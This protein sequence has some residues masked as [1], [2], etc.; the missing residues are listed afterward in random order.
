MSVLSSRTRNTIK[1]SYGKSADHSKPVSYHGVVAS[2]ESGRWVRHTH[3]VL[4]NLQ[5]LFSE[6]Q[7]MESSYREF[8]I[9]G[10]QRSLGPYSESMLR[11]R[12]DQAIIG[13]LT[14]D[15]PNQQTVLPA[16]KRIINQKIEFAELIIAVRRT[17]GFTAAADFMRQGQNQRIMDEF[18]TVLRGLRSE[19]LRLLVVRDAEA[20]R[21]WAQSKGVVMFGTLLGVFLAA[22]TVWGVQ[23]DRSQRMIT[24]DALFSEKE[25]APKSPSTVSVTPSSA[26]TSW[27]ISLSLIASRKA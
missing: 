21:R 16:L 4:Q 8:V 7:K 23:R 6:V 17:R 2:Q 10:D 13:N 11:A 9:T 15:N 18:Q 22:A 27:G 26:R 20:Q 14:V 1:Q 25:R 24:E 3:E 12:N 19:E 5:E